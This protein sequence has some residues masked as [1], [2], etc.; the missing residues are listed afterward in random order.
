[1]EFKEIT[2]S[3]KYINQLL[4][5]PESGMGYHLVDVVL[6]NGVELK[7][8]TILN[9]EILRIPI[10]VNLS[11]EQIRKIKILNK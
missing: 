8:L 2:L 6:E 5:I 11:L 9:C 4:R 1:M 3:E 7:G 10:D